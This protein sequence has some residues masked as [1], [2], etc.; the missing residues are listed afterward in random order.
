MSNAVTYLMNV[1]I[2]IIFF[3]NPKANRLELRRGSG[4]DYIV[5]YSSQKTAAID[6]ERHLYEMPHNVMFMFVKIMSDWVEFVLQ[7]LKK[8]QGIQRCTVRQIH[9]FNV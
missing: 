6:T 2:M 1:R 9:L 3:K 7:S 4:N 5:H 8:V